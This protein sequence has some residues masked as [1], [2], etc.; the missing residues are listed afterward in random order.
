MHSAQQLIERTRWFAL[1][2]TDADDEP[3][4]SYVP[5]VPVDRG[6]G[7]VVSALAAHTA[8]LLARPRVGVLIVGDE[9][10]DPFARPRLSIDAL[11]RQMSGTDRAD[12]LWDALARRN[13]PTVDVLRTLSDFRLFHLEPLHGRLVL[14]FAQ[15]EDLD[16][17]ALAGLL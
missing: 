12:A 15:A 16:A 14:G 9:T 5:F 1:A 17:E 4:V 13:G 3:F 7:I 6:F 8:H 10:N 11:A 2:T